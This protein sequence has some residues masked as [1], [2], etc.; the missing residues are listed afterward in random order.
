LARIVARIRTLETRA[1]MGEEFPS[2]EYNRHVAMVALTARPGC[3]LVEPV[4]TDEAT[5]AYIEATRATARG[6]H[7]LARALRAEYPVR[8]APCPPE[9]A[10]TRCGY[11]AWTSRGEHDPDAPKRERAI[12]AAVARARKRLGR[13][14]HEEEW[15]GDAPEAPEQAAPADEHPEASGRAKGQRTC[16]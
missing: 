16:A 14:E 3:L 6:D 15:G 12:K 11:A 13:P 4:D 5:Y 7:R 2:G 10:A 1:G 9:I 8:Y